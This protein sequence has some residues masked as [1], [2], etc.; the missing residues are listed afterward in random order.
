M[1]TRS[2]KNGGKVALLMLAF[3]AICA[4]LEVVNSNALN[5]TLGTVPIWILYALERLRIAEYFKGITLCVAILCS[6]MAMFAFF[7]FSPEIESEFFQNIALLLLV[8]ALLYTIYRSA[9]TS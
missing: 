2:I 3:S 4:I 7:K 5:P 9:V 1:D 8:P 6:I